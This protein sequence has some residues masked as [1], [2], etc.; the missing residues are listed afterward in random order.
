MVLDNRWEL[1]WCVFSYL[2]DIAYRLRLVS[3][4]IM[5]I[6]K[7]FLLIP[8][9]LPTLGES[10]KAIWKLLT[11]KYEKIYANFLQSLLLENVKFICNQYLGC[12]C[13]HSSCCYRLLE[14]YL[15]STSCLSMLYLYSSFLILCRK[16]RTS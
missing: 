16:K 9:T 10:R 6:E 8:L 5:S 14:N 12:K 1:H 7:I 2:C 4:L 11:L 15:F 3:N 13:L